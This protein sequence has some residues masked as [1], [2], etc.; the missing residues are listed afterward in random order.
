MLSQAETNERLNTWNNKQDE[1]RDRKE[2]ETE[3]KLKSD[4]FRKLYH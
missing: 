3:N 2:K 1:K 4:D